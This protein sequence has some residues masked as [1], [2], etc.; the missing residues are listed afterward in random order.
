MHDIQ[1]HLEV[2]VAVHRSFFPSAIPLALVAIALA[3]CS[4]ST[5]STGD[6]GVRFNVASRA[7][8][9]PEAPAGS[10]AGRSMPVT[11]TDGTNTLIVERVQIVL[12]EV[13][14]ERVSDAGCASGSASGDD[15]ACEKLEVGPFLLDVPLGVGATT[16]F[17]IAVDTGH[18]RE[19]EFE[20]HKASDD[21]DEDA[22]FIAANPDFEDVSIRVTGTYNG[23]AFTYLTDLNAEQ[24][25]ALNPTLVVTEAGATD[26]TLLV[27]VDRWFR[28]GG[29]TLI[30]PATANDG[31]ANEDVVANNIEASFAAFEDH[32]RNGRDDHGGST[33]D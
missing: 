26:L 10:F 14:L 7:T 25:L 30:D 28:T 2:A 22:A 1:P 33:D 19:V 27:D 23:T 4:D 9:I 32:D 3:A 24:E 8:A 31:Q 12:R 15:D 20:V 17:T 29:G 16:Q 11:L 18:Y 13:E 5:G 21:D 6:A